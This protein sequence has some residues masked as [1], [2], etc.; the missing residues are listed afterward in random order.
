MSYLWLHFSIVHT[1][2]D[3]IEIDV[4]QC[5][6][7][8]KCNCISHQRGRVTFKRR[9]KF[10]GDQKLITRNA[11]H[12]EL[13]YAKQIR[14]VLLKQ[15]GKRNSLPSPFMCS[16]HG[17]FFCWNRQ[18]EKKTCNWLTEGLDWIQTHFLSFVL[19]SLFNL[20]TLRCAEK[21]MHSFYENWIK[22]KSKSQKLLSFPPWHVHTTAPNPQYICVLYIRW[23]VITNQFNGIDN[24]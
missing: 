4:N 16:C 24:T 17:E 3:T 12:W 6:L 18:T 7:P 8:S 23:S 9:A 19:Y 13:S 1:F 22:E 20:Y 14:N 10:K 5:S 2:K 21:K 15:R 11:C